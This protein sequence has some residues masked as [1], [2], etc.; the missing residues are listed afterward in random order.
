LEVTSG[1][2]G[3]GAVVAADFRIER[4]ETFNILVGRSCKIKYQTFLL[5]HVKEL[6]FRLLRIHDVIGDCIVKTA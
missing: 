6:I 4:G 2:F 1:N 3:K 5:Q